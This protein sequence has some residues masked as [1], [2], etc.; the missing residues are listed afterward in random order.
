MSDSEHNL[1]ISRISWTSIL[2]LLYWSQ[3]FF[4]QPL[5]LHH[6][7]S[8]QWGNQLPI[9]VNPNRK[10]Y[11]HRNVYCMGNQTNSV[12]SFNV[13]HYYGMVDCVKCLFCTNPTEWFL[14]HKISVNKIMFGGLS[15]YYLF[16][17]CVERFVFQKS[18]QRQGSN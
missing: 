17:T 6:F 12:N 1:P 5:G 9:E 3:F 15:L 8:N 7:V 10:R 4:L 11:P 14:M 16:L 18:L 13:I 2:L